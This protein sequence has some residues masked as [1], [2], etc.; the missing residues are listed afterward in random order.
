MHADNMKFFTWKDSWREE[1]HVA[2]NESIN[3][4]KRKL[5][6]INDPMVKA[7][8]DNRVFNELVEAEEMGQKIAIRDCN[9]EKFYGF[10]WPGNS[11]WIDYYSDDAV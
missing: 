5:V 8:A 10:S 2:L 11:T 9:D 1:D 7:V 3:K 4:A 6:V